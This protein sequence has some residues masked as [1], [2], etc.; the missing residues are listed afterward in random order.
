MITKLHAACQIPPTCNSSGLTTSPTTPFPPPL[1]HPSIPPPPAS[2]RGL[3]TDIIHEHL[4]R[5]EYST[6]SAVMK[7]ELPL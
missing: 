4:Q 1:P 3:A 6:A 5:A 7:R 2:A